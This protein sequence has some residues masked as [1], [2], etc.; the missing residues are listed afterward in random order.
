MASLNKYKLAQTGGFTTG[1]GLSDSLH[2]L[3]SQ[4]MRVEW[5]LARMRVFVFRVFVWFWRFSCR[6]CASTLLLLGNTS[7]IK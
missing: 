2:V 7:R 6:V 4:K 5:V 1:G 3:L